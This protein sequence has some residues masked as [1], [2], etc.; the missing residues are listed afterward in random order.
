LKAVICLWFGINA[1]R[2]LKS[3][4][5]TFQCVVQVG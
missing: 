4:D 2:K 1:V 5:S 3:I